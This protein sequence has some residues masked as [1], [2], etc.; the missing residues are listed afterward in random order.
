VALAFFISGAP[1]LALTV[2][3]ILKTSARCFGERTG[4]AVLS[5]SRL[6]TSAKRRDSFFLWRRLVSAEQQGGRK[7]PLPPA[8]SPFLQFSK[9]VFP[10]EPHDTALMNVNLQIRFWFC[11]RH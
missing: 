5:I 2:S 3:G 7:P 1:R 6:R 8:L 9:G 10:W 11:A 4:V